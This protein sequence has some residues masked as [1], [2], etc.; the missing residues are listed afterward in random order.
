MTMASKGSPVVAAAALPPAESLGALVEGV[1]RMA[2]QRELVGMAAVAAEC[3]AELAHGVRARCYYVNLEQEQLWT[4]EGDPLSMRGLAGLAARQRQSRVASRAQAEP[5]YCREIDDPEG[6]GGERLLAQPILATQDEVHAVVVVARSPA[7]PPFGAAELSVLALWAEQVAPLF[8]MLHLEGIAEEAHRASEVAGRPSLYRE[9]ALAHVSTGE[10]DLGQLVHRLPAWLFH[11]HWL[12][13]AWISTTALFFALV[14]V[15]EY[16]SGPAFVASTGDRN[17]A[18]TSSGVVE[19]ILVAPGDRVERGQ[20]LATF[21][22]QSRQAELTLAQAELE[23]AVLARLRAPADPALEASVARA[24]G[25][26]ELAAAVVAAADVRANT[27]GRIGDLRVDIGRSVQAGEI[28]MTIKGDDMRPPTVRALVPGRHRPAV[29]IGQ[30]FTFNLDG[31]A[32]APQRLSVSAV[33]EAVIG[34]HEM[35]RVV[36]PELADSLAI[37]G[38]VIFVDAQLDGPTIEA[39]GRTWTLRAGMVGRTDVAVRHKPL[40]YLLFPGLE[41]LLN[42]V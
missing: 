4:P 37:E 30:P 33:S 18:A 17:V 15:K 19:S 7:L 9:E 10:K 26:R 3:A 36:G 39:D 2:L 32:N 41:R 22:A 35:R 42:D 12:A 40:G 34:P 5:G 13:V 1:R 11:S 31:F 8:H 25:D 38:P 27:T 24:R 14:P 23:R 6:S 28:L 16:A 29:E 20:L 21:S